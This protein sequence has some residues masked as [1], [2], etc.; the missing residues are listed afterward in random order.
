MD[1]L[2]RLLVG[3]ADDVFANALGVDEGGLHDLAVG[4][5]VLRLFG[6]ALIFALQL[7]D[8]LL[9]P[10]HLAG[11]GLELLFHAVQEPVHVLDPIAAEALFKLD[12]VYVLRCQHTDFL[13]SL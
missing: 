1:D 7:L 9:Q 3:L 4:A 10:V 2:L 5:V 8:L 13:L 12:R 6:E 11:A